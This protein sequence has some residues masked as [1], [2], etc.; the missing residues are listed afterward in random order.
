MPLYP[1]A[2]GSTGG[3]APQ[4]NYTAQGSTYS[5]LI[6]DYVSCSGT[7][8]T[9][10]M[11]TAVGNTGKT[12]VIQHLG[13][14]LTQNYTLATVSA[15]TIGGFASTAIVM[16]TNGEI[17]TLI[18]DG[19][20]WQI[21]EHKAQTPWITA[22]PLTIT[23]TT[24]NPGKGANTTDTFFWRRDGRDCI[25]EYRY[26]QTGAGTAGTGDYVFTLP[27][28]L[29]IDTASGLF[30]NTTVIGAPAIYYEPNKFGSGFVANQVILSG[31][32]VPIMYSTTQFRIQFEVTNN[33]VN[34]SFGVV[35]ASQL[36]LGGTNVSYYITARFP[37]VGWQP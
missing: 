18:S 35:S 12:V 13:T 2:G 3:G 32:G 33:A 8:F 17:F 16:Y 24:T 22:G 37:N 1:P 34:E 15:Q 4:W 26:R 5:A 27:S 10:T 30:A 9:V 25:F 7:S 36:G 23:A 29:N 6:N 19:T 28:G 11:P 31:L 21:F 20:N 14:S